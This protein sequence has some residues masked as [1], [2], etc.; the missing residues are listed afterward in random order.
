MPEGAN[1]IWLKIKKLLFQGRGRFIRHATLWMLGVALLL[2]GRLP[3][4]KLIP[5][6]TS[7]IRVSWNAEN[8]DFEFFFTIKNQ[9]SKPA[10]LQAILLL[11]G[12]VERRWRGVKLPVVPPK[13][14]LDFSFS[15]P[16]AFLLKAPFR[17]LILKVYGK[18]Y[19]IFADKSSNYQNLTMDFFKDKQK[20]VL[21]DRS[22]GKDKEIHFGSKQELSDLLKKQRNDYIQGVG[23]WV[24]GKLVKITGGHI[25]T[26]LP[27]PILIAVGGNKKVLLSYNRIQGARSYTLFWSNQPGVSAERAKRIQ[28]IEN[29]FIHQ[30]LNNGKPY[31]YA[32]AAVGAAGLGDLSDEVAVTPNPRPPRGPKAKVKP[33]DGRLTLT[34]KEV[35][36]ATGYNLRWSRDKEQKAREWERVP[37]V[38]SGFVHQGLSNKVT[39]YYRLY[40]LNQYGEG[41]SGAVFSG[42]PDLPKLAEAPIEELLLGLKVADFVQIPK[43]GALSLNIADPKLGAKAG[44]A[45]AKELKAMDL[46][47]RDQAIAMYIAQGQA[48]EVTNALN[49]QLE[50][51]P[52]NLNLSLSLSKVYAEQGNDAAALNVLTASLGRISLSAR[53]ALN[54]ELKSQIKAGASQL[55]GQ[56]DEAFLAEEFKRLGLSLLNKQKYGDA[57]SAFQSLKNLMPGYPLVEYYLGLARRGLQQ[58]TQAVEH[59]LAQNTL[60]T[61]KPDLL[62]NLDILTQELSLTR[63][64]KS[65]GSAL[66]AYEKVKDEADLD[67]GEAQQVATNQAA[68]QALFAAIEKHRREGL[69]DLGIA[70]AT[71]FRF[72]G[73]QPG[74]EI[75]LDF[76]VNNSGKKP[77][78]DFV[79]SYIVQNEA[80]MNFDILEKDRFLSLAAEA[81][82]FKFQKKLTLPVGLI[83]AKY[84]LIVHVEQVENRGEWSLE[85]NKLISGMDL[86]VSEPLPDLYIQVAAKAPPQVHPGMDI[87][88]AIR[89]LNQGLAKSS[90][91][92]I[93]YFLESEK[94]EKIPIF[95]EE[96]FPALL[97]KQAAREINKSLRLPDLAAGRYQVI[98]EV[99]TQGEEASRENNQGS[100]GLVIYI[101]PVP[102]DLAID[103][104]GRPR[105]TTLWPGKSFE[106]DFVLKNYGIEQ[107]GAFSVSYQL[108]AAGD[109]RTSIGLERRFDSLRS[110]GDEDWSEEF[111]IP[112]DLPPGDYRLEASVQ[113]GEGKDYNDKNNFAQSSYLLRILTEEEARLA[114]GIEDP[115]A[116][117]SKE[118]ERTLTR[119][120]PPLLLAFS[121]LYLSL[122]EQKN[123]QA[124]QSEREQ[125]FAAYATAGSPAEVQSVRSQLASNASRLEGSVQRNNS[126]DALLVAGLLWEGYTLF[127]GP[128]PDEA[129]WGDDLPQGFWK[130]VGT[131]SLLALGLYQGQQEQKLAAQKQSEAEQLVAGYATLSSP[132]QFAGQAAALTAAQ[133]SEKRHLAKAKIYDAF[134]LLA[135]GVEAWWIYQ[136]LCGEDILAFHNPRMPQLSLTPDFYQLGWNIGLQWRW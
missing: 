95:K 89:P 125:L 64:L 46:A 9:G 4:A 26:K 20:V 2:P 70:F 69:P 102:L 50:E 99:T 19:N 87:E 120:V 73:L 121:G 63:D 104:E 131:G 101:A 30:G 100:S 31:Y 56:S 34:W 11:K 96:E 126:Y 114:G 14:E 12:G 52:E 29:N 74:Q 135:L 105:R 134:T 67:E 21:S 18:D 36:G 10:E 127:L 66:E 75:Y 28:N 3:A 109:A 22:A 13:S 41:R 71:P 86:E 16:A 90:P 32:I 88:L 93:R 5:V 51:E 130:H 48:G 54:Q 85:D 72:K 80:G 79:V 42:V 8:Q 38:K 133:E 118:T 43:L 128:G 116:W 62:K 119:H 98:A 122:L 24:N 136:D 44:L 113:L 82:P 76:I 47:Q 58:H 6:S 92:R 94:G 23:V 60:E 45:Q 97:P 129:T 84:R 132:T 103:L 40:A 108:V 91:Y 39:Y 124:A 65:I 53:L 81:E 27:A 83:P 111:T 61:P 25:F 106:Q 33:G 78:S 49:A 15:L 123:Y 68:L 59:F 117:V 110:K 55:T 57:L 107:A 115:N 77:S 1:S 17:Q 35:K 7:P 37:Q 112:T